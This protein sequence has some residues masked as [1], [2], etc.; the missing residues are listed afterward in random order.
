MK[1]D[2]KFRPDVEFDD[3]KCLVC[4]EYLGYFRYT[5]ELQRKRILNVQPQCTVQEII[6]TS[7]RKHRLAASTKH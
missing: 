7:F 1:K 5:E 4:L 3:S 6:P 2:T